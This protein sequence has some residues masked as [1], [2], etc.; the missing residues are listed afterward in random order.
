MIQPVPHPR[1]RRRS[2]FTLIELLVVLGLIVLA[3]AAA[4]PAFNAITGSRSTEAAENVVGAMLSRARSLAVEGQQTA[5]VAFFVNPADNRTT[6]ALVVHKSSSNQLQ[7]DIYPNYR[8]WAKQ[9]NQPNNSVAPPTY[10]PGQ[11]VASV[12][13]DSYS[14][15]PIVGTFVN[16]DNNPSGSAAA[17]GT[18]PPQKPTNVATATPWSNS[19]WSGLSSGSIEFLDFAG[20]FEF[21]ALPAGVA[22][23][24]INDPQ[25]QIQRDRYVQ[26]GVILFDA[27]GRLV[28][29]PYG[30]NNPNTPTGRSAIAQL[31]NISPATYPQWP[32]IPPAG[33]PEFRTQIGLV[34]YDRSTFANQPGHTEGDFSV[35]VAGIPTLSS[36]ATYEPERLEE[37]WIDENTTPLLVNR[38]NGAIMRGQ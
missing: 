25:G 19:Y 32:R 33:T 16:T 27:Q 15:K 11:E 6:M 34:I 29:L 18:A 12:V 26:I 10:V 35:L 13:Y 24:L 4:V 28:S 38:Y 37:L 21:E 17:D 9:A 1:P 23:Q 3:L 2:A 8:G 7:E 5:G 36:P 30:F 31:L 20:E 22:V 14:R